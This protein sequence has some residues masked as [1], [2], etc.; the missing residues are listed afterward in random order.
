[1]P[2]T[3]AQQYLDYFDEVYKQASVTRFLETPADM[4]EFKGVNT[5]LINKLTI[6]G[7][8]DY[9]KSSGYTAG[10]VAN[11]WDSYTLAMDRGVKLPIDAVDAEEAR[12][13]AAR[14]NNTYLR[15]KFFP[16]LDLYR[17][18]KM[19]TDIAGSAVAGTNIVSATLSFDNVV[20]A[21]DTGIA[22][23]DNAEVPK[24]GRI[25][26]V[27]ETT[28][29]NMKKSGEVYNTRLITGNSQV[30]N[31]DIEIFDNMPLMRV[32]AGRFNSAATFGAGS[33]TLTGQYINFII[34]YRPALMAII[35]RNVLRIFSPEQQ[36][37]VD[38][39]L[40]TARNYHGLNV[41]TNKVAGVY[42]HKK[43][44]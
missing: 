10:T 28:Y 23:L 4:Y 13:T 42:I 27:S 11:D 44:A 3:A 2:I 30:L 1:M 25:L 41:Y 39:W 16:E 22:V 43:A 24:D 18:T 29:Q 8:Y 38:G 36:T 6:S 21:I 33:N 31:R 40:M 35:K 15:E 17:F 5:V 20:N 7:N 34:L 14:I 26:F 9:S 37:D 32:P 19:Y 12:I